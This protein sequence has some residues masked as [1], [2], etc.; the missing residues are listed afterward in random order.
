MIK[1]GITGGIGS[2]KS[3]ISRILRLLNYP[4]Y[5]SD[6]WAKELMNNNPNIQHALTKRFGPETYQNNTLNRP[7]LAKQIFNNEDARLFVN[8]IVH[9]IVSQHFLD[10]AENQNTKLVFIESAI[11]FS[12]GLNKLLDETIY[13]DA[14]Q[15]IR[16]QRAMARDNAS[17]EAIIARINSQQQDNEYAIAHSTHIIINDNQ[18]LLIPQILSILQTAGSMEPSQCAIRQSSIFN[19]SYLGKILCKL[20]IT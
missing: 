20:S 9:P 14:P 8:S 16:L 5:D 11:L 17:A 3:V 18:T 12:S 15:P 2:G 19:T 1:I 13:V 4:V 10:W 7:F 6:F